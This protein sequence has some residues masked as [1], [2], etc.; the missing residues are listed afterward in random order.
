MSSGSKPEDSEED[1]KAPWTRVVKRNVT[2]Y[3]NTES[4]CILAM[5]LIF[6][7]L[8]GRALRPARENVQMEEEMRV[9]KTQ[10]RE[11]IETDLIE[12]VSHDQI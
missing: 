4:E 1:T 12:R 9:R 7:W 6:T 10:M 5:Q 3:R 11:L 2:A 8:V